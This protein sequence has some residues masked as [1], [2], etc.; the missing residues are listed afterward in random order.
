M[1]GS[2]A[3]VALA[4]FAGGNRVLVE[5][6]SATDSGTRFRAAYALAHVYD[7]SSSNEAQAVRHAIM[8]GLPGDQ[9]A[10][11][12]GVFHRR[13]P[14]GILPD[15][16]VDAVFPVTIRRQ[17]SGRPFAVPGV[18]TVPPLHDG[19]RMLR[20]DK[21]REVMARRP[22]FEERDFELWKYQADPKVQR[23]RAQERGEWDRLRL[24]IVSKPG[25]RPPCLETCLSAL[26]WA[27]WAGMEVEPALEI[28][29]PPTTE[30]DWWTET[31]FRL[32]RA[33]AGDGAMLD[34]LVRDVGAMVQPE[35]RGALLVWL[36]EMPPAVELRPRV[37]SA[38]VSAATDGDPRIRRYAIELLAVRPE[39]RNEPGAEAAFS[40][41]LSDPDPDVR[42]RAACELWDLPALS[43]DAA[44]KI[45]AAL[46]TES[47]AVVGHVLQL[48]LE[49][50]R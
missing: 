14:D 49:R 4:V 18:K 13:W 46:A 5:H 11:A 43:S 27:A 42:V 8:S 9:A 39:L 45:R 30:V 24:D 28:R 29:R 20:E 17:P 23:E 26:M 40:A 2:S 21:A 25:T 31:M 48:I 3:L 16:L 35:S 44:A 6:L 38:V 1:V 33:S 7:T 19:L 47:D 50:G 32:V 37:R 10:A 12:D 41:A 22:G 36:V 34:T 15:D